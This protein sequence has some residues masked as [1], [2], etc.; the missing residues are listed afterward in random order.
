MFLDSSRYTKRYTKNM[1]LTNT[2]I[3][4]H[5]SVLLLFSAVLYE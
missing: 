1:S 4:V 2:N 5:C 3:T